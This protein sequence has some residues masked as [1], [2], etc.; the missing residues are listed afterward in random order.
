MGLFLF[1]AVSFSLFLFCFFVS[2][3]SLTPHP[4]FFSF[5]LLFFFLFVASFFLSHS[6]F[7]FFLFFSLSLSLP[8]SPPLSPLSL[9]PSLSLCSRCC[10]KRR[11]LSQHTDLLT[12]VSPKHALYVQETRGTEFGLVCHTKRAEP[13]ALA[14]L[15]KGPR[16]RVCLSHGTG[17][18]I[19][20]VRT[21][22]ALAVA[23]GPFGLFGPAADSSGRS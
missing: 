10:I 6:F 7:F 21:Y 18:I 2:V 19:G 17:G 1:F 12:P 14:E 4:P 5:F 3:F 22:V 23:T 11:P 20:R 16:R 8:L 9:P 13:A 15:E